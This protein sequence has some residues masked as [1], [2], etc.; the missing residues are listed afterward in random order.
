MVAITREC[1]FGRAREVG[2]EVSRAEET[3]VPTNIAR[4]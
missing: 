1:Y 3:G 4:Q 2:W